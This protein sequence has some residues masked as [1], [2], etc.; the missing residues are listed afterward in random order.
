[1]IYER[2]GWGALV[3]KINLISKGSYYGKLNG[4]IYITDNL[5]MRLCES[6]YQHISCNFHSVRLQG[7]TF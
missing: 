1:M 3:G 5:A 7:W 4:V 6:H 2:C